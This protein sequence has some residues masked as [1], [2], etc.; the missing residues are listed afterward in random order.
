MAPAPTLQGIQ[1][2]VDVSVLRQRLNTE[3]MKIVNAG[4]LK[5]GFSTAGAGLAW[6]TGDTLYDYFHAPADTLLA[7]TLAYPHLT[8]A[9]QSALE[10]YLRNE[11]A[12]YPPYQ[13]KY[14]GWRDGAARQAFDFPPEVQQA[15]ANHGPSQYAAQSFPGWTGDPQ[16]TP[17]MFYALWKYAQQFD[18]AQ[19]I[20]N[21]NRS[22]FNSPPADDVLAMYPFA[23][24]AWIAG[25]VGYI[26]L[27]KLAGIP[28]NQLTSYQQTLDR[29]LSLRATN[30]NKD[31]PW[32]PDS[33]NS[34]QSFS[35]ARNFLFMTPE[36]G[37]YLRGHALPKVQAAFDEYKDIAPYWFVS[38]FEATYGEAL[39]HHLYDTPSLFLAKAY[40]FNAPREEL[41]KYLDVPAFERGDLFY[42]QNLVATIEAGPAGPPTPPAKPKGL[43]VR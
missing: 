1:D 9:N 24:N 27:A 19:T 13:Y 3:I 26:N 36:L 38:N 21:N 30:F 15:L 41:A 7:L 31:N 20:F 28:D 32:G 16:W 34:N 22:C 23:H 2:A 39:I 10:T 33:H 12:A 43:R 18:N 11:Y 6:V 14:I 35:V 29:L 5:P 42:I 25:Y 40:I 37:Q 17:H 8:P 4:H